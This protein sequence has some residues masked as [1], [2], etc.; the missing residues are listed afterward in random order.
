V[1]ETAG[2]LERRETVGETAGNLERQETVG[3]TI[4]KNKKEKKSE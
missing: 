2:N 1:G 3:E 4:R